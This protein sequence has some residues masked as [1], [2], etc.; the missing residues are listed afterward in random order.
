MASRNPADRTA[1]AWLW[2][3]GIVAF[4]FLIRCYR[5]AAD[6]VWI[7]EAASIGL[8][9]LPWSVV[10][11]EMARIEASPPG[12][13]AIA[14]VIGMVAGPQ[15][16]PLRLVS[17]AAAAFAIVPL[18]MFCREA[19][20]SR[21]AWTAGLIV[22]LHALLFRMSQDG[23][24]YA[25]LFL[26]FCCALLAAW[27]LVAAARRGEAGVAAI[28]ALGLCQGGM[29]WLHH[30]AGI[31]NLALNAFVLTVLVA[32]RQ[33]VWRGVVLLVAADAVGLAIGAA[34]IWWALQHAVE[35]AFVTRWIEPPGLEEASLIYTRGLVAPYHQPVSIIT[36]MLSIAGVLIGVFAARQPGWPARLGL[37][38]LLGSAA[39]LFPLVSQSWPVM[40]DRTV[41]FMAAPLAASIAGGLAL[42]PRSAFL[43]TVAV[44]LALHAHG[45]VGYIDW[46][47]H[48]ERWDD[49]A[50]LLR[51]RASPGDRVVVT[52]SVFAA[53]S[54]RMAAIEQG[55]LAAPILLVPAASPLES[56]SAELLDPASNTTI[57]D[58]C[59]RLHG[60]E[61]V[62]LVARPVPEAVEADPGFSTWR[63]VRAALRR[64]GGEE[65]DDLSS[66]TV[67]VQRWRVPG[68]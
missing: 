65:V 61:F 39:L 8:G 9:S 45:I 35:G 5:I 25:I 11:G 56:R 34:P 37:L 50:G 48:K 13:Y 32:S 29:L 57:G 6:P 58:L 59:R 41:L 68:C 40:L 36:G 42:L 19:L 49:A 12:Y 44:L 7:D 62:W 63:P 33:G 23:R 26:M 53:I 43:G 47:T 16:L 30:T 28:L 21:A 24:T 67:L 3:G 66:P 27:R 46:P 52:D 2:L 14:K 20:G 22:A 64:A 60:A 38:A 4:A 10:F 31:A 54:L 18:W 1:S 15:G 55:G 17:A 51:A